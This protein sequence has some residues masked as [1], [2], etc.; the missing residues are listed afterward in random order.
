MFLC[1]CCVLISSFS[2]SNLLL[3]C[4]GEDILTRS[5]LLFFYLLRKFIIIKK[6]SSFYYYF[7]SLLFVRAYTEE[8]LFLF[9]LQAIWLVEKIRRV[10]SWTNQNWASSYVNW[11]LLLLIIFHLSEETKWVFREVQVQ[12]ELNQFLCS[13]VL[14]FLVRI[15][16]TRSSS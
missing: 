3:F 5:L 11:I 14:L 16:S 1:C 2:L 8:L 9:T 6:A 4:W 10:E 7:V 13:C 15:K 12:K